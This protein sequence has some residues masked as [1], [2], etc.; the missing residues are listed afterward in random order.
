MAFAVLGA[1]GRIRGVRSR[2]HFPSASVVKAMLL[3][4]EL[5]RVGSRP[6]TG[7]ERALLRPMIEVSDN[8]AA[9]SIYGIVG[10]RRAGLGRAGWPGCAASPSASCSTRS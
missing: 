3:V 10:A 1:D 4:A 9:E 6:L 8:Q 7:S 2:E 5:R